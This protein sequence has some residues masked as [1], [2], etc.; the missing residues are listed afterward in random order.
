VD[1]GQPPQQQQQQQPGPLLSEREIARAEAEELAWRDLVRDQLRSLRTGMMV[2]APLALVALGIALWAL[3]GDDSGSARRSGVSAA[4]VV[5]LERQVEKIRSDIES[6]PSSAAIAS[7][8]ARQQALE[9]EIATL[10]DTV[11]QRDLQLQQ[12]LDDLERQGAAPTPSAP[13][14]SATP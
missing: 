10:A 3:L 4:R 13:A 5:A 14:P 8:Q 2:L 9:K 12:R 1:P 11:Q 7:V 6:R